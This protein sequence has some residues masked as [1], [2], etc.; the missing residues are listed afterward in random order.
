M[1]FCKRNLRDWK[2]KTL[3]PLYIMNMCSQYFIIHSNS[4]YIRFIFPLGLLFIK[5]AIYLFVN[6]ALSRQL[7]RFYK[8]VYLDFILETIHLWISCLRFW[9]IITFL[10]TIFKRILVFILTYDSSIFLNYVVHH[11]LH[12][13]MMFILT[14]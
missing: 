8:S 14:T 12:F 1:P 7:C 10:W 3:Y 5:T 6:R 2:T 13:H 4:S 11:R 9:L